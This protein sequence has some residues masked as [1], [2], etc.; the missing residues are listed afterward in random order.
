MAGQR[1]FDSGLVTG[2]MLRWNLLSDQ[3]QRVPNDVYLYVITA[4]GYNGQLLQSRVG[5]LLV[6]R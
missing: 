1:M 4:K 3:G 2:H 6:L 5:K